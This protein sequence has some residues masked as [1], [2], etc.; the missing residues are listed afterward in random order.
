MYL[1]KDV[2]ED[3]PIEAIYHLINS[4]EKYLQIYSGLVNY[5]IENKDEFE[6]MDNVVEFLIANVAA[7]VENEISYCNF[8]KQ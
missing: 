2:I 3:L 5:V 7:A 1:S 6:S 4:K 8:T